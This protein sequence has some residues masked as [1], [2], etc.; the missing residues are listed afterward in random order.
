MLE[1]NFIYSKIAMNVILRNKKEN[2]DRNNG[3]CD[4]F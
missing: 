4:F 3:V 1:D 2:K